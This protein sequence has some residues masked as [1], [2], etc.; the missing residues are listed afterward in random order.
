MGDFLDDVA[1]LM[2]K[3]DLFRSYFCRSFNK[4]VTTSTKTAHLMARI[5]DFYPIFDAKMA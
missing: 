4:N 5:G 1:D 2:F 3:F